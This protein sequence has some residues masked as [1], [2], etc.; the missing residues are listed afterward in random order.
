[1][2]IGNKFFLNNIKL[3]K[4]NMKHIEIIIFLLKT[5]INKKICI[6]LNFRSFKLGENE[7][8][9]LTNKEF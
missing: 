4:K 1:M 2:K 3:I 7:F 6:K 9:D 5:I 8:M